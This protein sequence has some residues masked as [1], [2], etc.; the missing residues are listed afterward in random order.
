MKIAILSF[1]DS[2]GGAADACIDIYKN[3]DKKKLSSFLILREKKFKI[4]F[5]LEIDL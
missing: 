5:Y 2:N 1:S 4:R 3:L